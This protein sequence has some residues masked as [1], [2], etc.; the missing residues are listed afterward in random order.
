MAAPPPFSTLRRFV[1]G[2]RKLEHCELCGAPLLSEHPH[3]LQLGTRQIV[4][5]CQACGLL[6]EHRGGPGYRR[7]GEEVRLLDNFR[8]TDAEWESLAIP[9]GL[10]F[11]V[12]NSSAKRVQGF[13]PGPAG[14]TESRLPVDMPLI[15]D[16]EPDIEALL[17]NRV[18]SA[19]EHL[20][21]PIDRCYRLAGVIRKHWQGLSGGEVV[22]AEIDRF[23]AEQRESARA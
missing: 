9:I 3:L 5:S 10:A 8:M 11:F 19:R 2:K 18:G 7:I 23:F 14:V 6:F 16:L 13:Y 15:R 21:V 1:P 17:V 20:V 22:W 4:C 12:F